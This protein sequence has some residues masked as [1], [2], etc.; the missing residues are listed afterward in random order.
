MSDPPIID[1]DWLTDPTDIA[2]AIAGIRRSREILAYLASQGLT[3]GV[4]ALP[5]ANVTSDEDILHYVQQSL[6]QIYHAAAT[7]KMGRPSDK[8]AVLDS[9]ARVYG[10]QNLRVVDASSFPFLTPGHLQSVVYALAEKIAADIIGGDGVAGGGD[11]LNGTNGMGYDLS[12]FHMDCQM[13]G[14][15][16]CA[17]KG[18]IVP[19]GDGGGSKPDSKNVASPRLAGGSRGAAVTA[20]LL[21][22]TGFFWMM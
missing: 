20:G 19:G 17:A 18:G 8:L 14:S 16:A 11:M 9:R 12:G 6:I 15:G 22:L 7:C 5:G 1:P 21:T 4:E 3:D 2:L 13:S 10:A